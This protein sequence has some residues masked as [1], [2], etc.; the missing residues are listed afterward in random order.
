MRS[1]AKTRGDARHHRTGDAG[2]AQRLDLFAAAS[3]HEGVAA[4][5]AHHALARLGRIDQTR[6]DGVLA[7]PRF[8]DPTADRHARRVAADA[9]ENLRRYQL[10]VENDIG[11]L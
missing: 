8:S 6:V 1:A 3:E 7:D 5:Q 2:T 10:V 4:L 9:V 11:V